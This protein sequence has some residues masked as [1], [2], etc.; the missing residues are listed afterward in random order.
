MSIMTTMSIMTLPA[1]KRNLLAFLLLFATASCAEVGEDTLSTSSPL[2]IG[3][4][5]YISR[6]NMLHAID[7]TTGTGY[8]LNVDLPNAVAMAS[9]NGKG[10]VILENTSL[11]QQQMLYT[12]NTLVS[13][14][15]TV[16]NP[17]TSWADTDAMTALAGNLYVVSEDTLWRVNATSGAT[18]PFSA[19]PDGW[20]DTEAMA[21]L[22]DSVYVVQAGTL[23]RVNVN[24][25][26][27]VPFSAYPDGWVGTEAMTARAGIL[28]AAAAGALWTVNTSSG[29]VAQLG[30]LPWGGTAAM[31]ARL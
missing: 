6:A 25:G 9:I 16:L 26:S 31:A 20:V 13:N 29:S 27:V 23:W 8:R 28:Y 5:V 19:Y 3:N 12:F 24:N 22:G 4:E 18:V 11:P 10:Y 17:D 14:R 30:S 1:P 21:A 7:S 15:L 2:L